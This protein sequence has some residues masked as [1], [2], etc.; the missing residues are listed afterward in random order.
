MGCRKIFTAKCKK[1]FSRFLALEW[2]KKCLSLWCNHGMNEHAFM[3]MHVCM[4]TKQPICIIK[5]AVY[6]FNGLFFWPSVIYFVCGI[7]LKSANLFGVIFMH[8]TL[9]LRAQYFKLHLY[10][11]WRE[12][13]KKRNI[14]SFIHTERKR[15]TK[16]HFVHCQ[17]RRS[18]ECRVH[19]IIIV[20]ATVCVC[21]SHRDEFD[22]LNKI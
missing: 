2:S 3:R 13:T 22:C 5:Y 14:F 21:A 19:I 20:V 8:V 11:W 15:N 1:I 17:G 16:T 4:P 12:W 6:L 7:S 10:G 18:A 9:T